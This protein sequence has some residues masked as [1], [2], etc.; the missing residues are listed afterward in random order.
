ME[1]GWILSNSA[2]G[3]LEKTLR[4][5]TATG[6]YVFA[7]GMVNTNAQSYPGRRTVHLGMTSQNDL[8]VL[9][10]R[11]AAVGLIWGAGILYNA[12]QIPGETKVRNDLQIQGNFAM[13]NPKRAAGLKRG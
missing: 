8:M 6:E 11:S 10:Q 9:V 1:L 12:L 4:G 5:G 13:M 7:D 2:A 3:Q